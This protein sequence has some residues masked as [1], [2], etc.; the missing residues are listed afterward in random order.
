MSIAAAMCPAGQTELLLWDAVQPGLVV[1]V[2]P[3]GTKTYA[4]RFRPKGAGRAAAVR[5]VA[6]GEVGRLSLKA[7]REAAK[8]HLGEVA[9]GSDPAVEIQKKRREEKQ[10]AQARLSVVLDEYEADLTKR[11]VVKRKEVMSILRRE[12]LDRL[13]D[14]DIRTLDRAK[15]VERIGKVEADGRNGAAGYLRSKLPPFLNFAVNQG[16]LTA[17]PMAGWRKP[18]RTRE[19]RLDRTGRA[20]ADEELAPLWT[21]AEAV[22]WPFGLYVQLLL[23]LGQRR[24]ETA[25]MRHTDLDL[26]AG[27]WTIP[28][29]ITKMGRAQRVPLPPEAVAIIKKAPKRAGNKHVFAGRG[30]AAMS[31]FTKRLRELNG[32]LPGVAAWTLHDLRRTFRTGLG[33]LGVDRD[34]AELCIGHV[35]GDELTEI[36]DRGDYWKERSKAGHRWARHVMGLVE[37]KAGKVVAM[38][39]RA[40]G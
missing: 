36:Y 7:A 28:P 19:E 39:R 9:K 23:L 29:E 17:N 35:V 27:V 1:R 30:E 2:R 3:S 31:G 20:L 33:R 12:L 6:L 22:G 24:T 15:L 40:R 18:R 37:G 5:K 8:A 32:H 11:K 10:K 38:R 21:G 34:I 13:G 26:E 14:V 16:I 25:L 4:V